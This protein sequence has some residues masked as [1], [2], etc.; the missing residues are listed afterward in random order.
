MT[1]RTRSKTKSKVLAQE[2]V[3]K[4][5][6]MAREED[7]REGL[8]FLNNQDGDVELIESSRA[9]QPRFMTPPKSNQGMITI[10]SIPP[11]LSK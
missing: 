10:F 5:K 6:I 8:S 9:E 3:Q 2:K 7:K 1:P 11:W 4:E